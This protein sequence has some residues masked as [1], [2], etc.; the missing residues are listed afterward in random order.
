M[1]TYSICLFDTVVSCSIETL[2]V[3]P[4]SELNVGFFGY[5]LSH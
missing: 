4:P 3:V 2:A 1:T 5:I